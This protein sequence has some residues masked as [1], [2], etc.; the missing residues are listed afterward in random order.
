MG[1]KNCA[2]LIPETQDET[3]GNILENISTMEAER[4]MQKNPS[5]IR[6]TS[7]SFIAENTRNEIVGNEK[8]QNI[9]NMIEGLNLILS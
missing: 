9:K 7:V 2:C 6:D 4:E 5:Y 3:L 8:I 1:N